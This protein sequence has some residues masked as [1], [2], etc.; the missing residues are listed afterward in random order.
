MS[1]GEKKKEERSE[2]V[3]GPISSKSTDLYHTIGVKILST[4]T[5]LQERFEP[6]E[7]S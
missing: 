4:E 5:E 1:G 7:I 6:T 3:K 2:D